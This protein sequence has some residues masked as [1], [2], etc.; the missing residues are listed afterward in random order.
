MCS[1]VV[2]DKNSTHALL[3]RNVLFWTCLTTKM[4]LFLSLH[5]L[6]DT[7]H[8]STNSVSLTSGAKGLVNFELG[9]QLRQLLVCTST[10]KVVILFPQ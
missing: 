4:G 2:R 7:E 6:K 10:S 9:L 1:S 8:D 5:S 3:M